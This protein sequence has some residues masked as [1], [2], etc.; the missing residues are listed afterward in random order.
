[1]LGNPCEHRERLRE[2]FTQPFERRG[3]T[4]LEREAPEARRPSTLRPA[5]PLLPSLLPFAPP[6][7]CR[8]LLPHCPSL[9][10]LC[11]S[12]TLPSWYMG[13]SGRA[14]LPGAVRR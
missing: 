14:L 6:P 11:S 8:S 9:L 12:A 1:M 2:P 4:T 5:A 7:V 3:E 10:P 13:I